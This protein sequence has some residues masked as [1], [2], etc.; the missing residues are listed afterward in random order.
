[1][2]LQR[3]TDADGDAEATARR[4]SAAARTTGGMASKM[5]ATNPPTA[6]R[7]SGVTDSPTPDWLAAHDW[8]EAE[9]VPV[10]ASDGA[11]VP[12]LLVDQGETDAFLGEQLRPELLR[13]ACERV[14]IPLTLRMQPGYDHSY[15][16]ISTFMADH[17]RW[18]GERMR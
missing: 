10:P 2:A 1:M 15:F 7:P 3:F 13:S 14:G 17:L 11:R 8:R 6:S 9:I 16:F 12:A 4:A 18:H 5:E